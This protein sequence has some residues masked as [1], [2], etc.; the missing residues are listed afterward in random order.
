M[1][2]NDQEARK[3]ACH[4]LDDLFDREVRSG[5]EVTGSMFRVVEDKGA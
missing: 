3:P 1:P 2:V 4:G 5:K